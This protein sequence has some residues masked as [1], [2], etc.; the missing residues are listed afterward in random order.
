MCVA[1]GNTEL[2]NFATIITTVKKLLKRCCIHSTAFKP[3]DTHDVPEGM[4]LMFIVCF[5]LNKSRS[6]LN[7]HTFRRKSF[8]QIEFHIKTNFQPTQNIFQLGP[9]SWMKFL[10]LWMDIYRIS[11]IF[12]WKRLFFRNHQNKCIVSIDVIKEIVYFKLR[13]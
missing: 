1:I 13:A 4:S 5:T 11:R 12:D 7:S 3:M 9:F 2:W 10:R 6:L 8:M